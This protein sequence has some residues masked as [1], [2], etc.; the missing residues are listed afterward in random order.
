MSG[1][2]MPPRL[3]RAILRHN[4]P[5]DVRDSVDGDLYELYLLR[6]AESGA[7]SAATW[8][9]FQ[10]FSFSMRFSFDRIVRA[11]REF[12]GGNA[13][14]SALDIKLGARMLAKSPGLALV[15][16]FGMAVAVALGAGGYAVVNSYFYPELPLHEG[17][18][19]IALAKFDPH[20]HAEDEQLLHD[21]LIW[22]RD[23]R[24]V[25]D[26]SAFREVRRNLVTETGQGE[27]ITIAAMTASGFRVARVPPLRG[28]VLVEEDER[29]GARPVVVIGYD[30]WQSR[31]G[32]NPSVVGQEI[33]IGRTAHSI[34]GIMPE[35]F[36]F[37]V[38]HQYWVPLQIDLRVPIAQQS[39]PNLDVFGRLARGATRASVQAE[40]SLINRRIA[41]EGPAE[42]AHIYARVVPF[43]DIFAHAEAETQDVTFG[44]MRFLIALLLVIVA[45]N[46]AVL[47]YARTVTRTGEIAVRT[48][49]GATRAR[50]VGQLFAEA[51]VLSALASL[52]GL[53]IVAVCLR[54]FDRSLAQ[55]FGRLPFW[56]HS[57]LSW[58]TVLYALSLAVLAAVIVGVLPAL[59]A[60][61]SQLRAA[62]GSLGSGA[63]ARLGPTWTALIV[64]Q[65]AIT[66]AILP[67]AMLKGWQTVQTARYRPGF[68]AGQYLSTQLLVEREVRTIANVHSDSAAA[69]SA[70]VDVT[71]LLARLETEPGVVG[72][73][74]T[75]NRPWEGTSAKMDVDGLNGPPNKVRVIT[76]DPNYFELFGVRAIAGRLFTATDGRLQMSDRPVIVNRSFATELLGGGDPVGRR[77]RYRSN[78]GEPNPW[79]TI[80]GVVEDF[81]AGVMSPGQGTLR[82]MYQLAMPGERPGGILTLR[83]RGQ[84]PEAF[85]PTLR[86][87]A[88]S[89]DPMLQLSS[90]GALETAYRDYTSEAKQLALVV[91]LIVGSVILLSSA[92][93]H[94]LISFTV[95][96]RRREI[97]IRTAL[98]AP[99]RRILTSVLA[100]A[101]RQLGIGVSLGL[102]VAVA[103]D[104]MSGG[105]LMDGSGLLL[106]PA[107][108]AFMLAVGLVAAAGPARRSLN[109]QPTETL[110]A[111]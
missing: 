102:I 78:G 101:S 85:I 21:F 82:M 70:R 75:D 81:P 80:A 27:P 100:R 87:T 88:T 26:L 76:V 10:A 45:T 39:G 41:V 63:K 9:W 86:R 79:L 89:V 6:R 92:G 61:G 57:G 83:L 8:Y 33:R 84:T 98:G 1:A 24:T 74:I 97:G 4:L 11:L 17:D 35:G 25:V 15:G 48:A 95:N 19:V 104:V 108:A 49:L 42:L 60:T 56:I 38:N 93:I 31:F 71:T 73:T 107:T 51:F 20:Q 28:R 106:V 68:P 5:N 47:V 72:A 69:D 105:A 90:T 91:V 37:P 94:A 50:I 12:A 34:V 44:L 22:R 65:I 77:I 16:G 40:L 58:G 111:E 54:M 13:A 3:A 59:R 52:V 18:R 30:V 103:G 7:A 96:Q 36:A 46:V 64:A 2:P 110:R 109:V 55:Y 14:P 29:P 23:M 43:T 32:G 67:V 66:V 99:A 53:G 62:M